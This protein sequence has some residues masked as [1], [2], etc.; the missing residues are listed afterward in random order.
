MREK[1]AKIGNVMLADSSQASRV[2]DLKACQCQSK[3]RFVQDSS[4]DFI[5][6]STKAEKVIEAISRRLPFATAER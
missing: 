4:H 6:L 5:D 3:L 2:G 1:I